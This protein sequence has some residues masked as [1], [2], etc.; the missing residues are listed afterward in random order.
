M[1]DAVELL[2]ET[3]DL[4]KINL[5]DPDAPIMKGKKGDFNTNYNGQLACSEDQIITYCDV[6]T[7]GNDKAQLV[8]A[9]KGVAVN[10]ETKVKIALADADYGTYYSIEYMHDEGICGYVPYKDMNSTFDDKPYHSSHFQYDPQRDIY[11][12]PANQKLIYIRTFTDKRR[13]QNFRLYRTAACKGCPFQSDCCSKRE[14]KRKIK[15]E[16][17]QDLWDEMKHRLNSEEGKKNVWS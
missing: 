9:L 14:K 11:I 10:T 6:V 17:R 8:P 16:T 13:A 5:T 3:E 2:R 4:D 1:C 7:A 12:C 15:R